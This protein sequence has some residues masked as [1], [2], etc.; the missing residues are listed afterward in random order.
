MV[1]G[2]GPTYF[3]NR[4]FGDQESRELYDKKSMEGNFKKSSLMP[5]VMKNNTYY[6]SYYVYMVYMLYMTYLTYTTDKVG[7]S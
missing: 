7:R 3:T 5:V 4:S 1:T 6:F 2:N